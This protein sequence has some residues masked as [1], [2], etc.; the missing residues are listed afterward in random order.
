MNESFGK[1]KRGSLNVSATEM[2]PD[3]LGG[4]FDSAVEIFENGWKEMKGK[5]I[6]AEPPIGIGLIK[7]RSPWDHHVI[8]R[9]IYCQMMIIRF[10]LEQTVGIEFPHKIVECFPP[11]KSYV[12]Y[13]KS[14]DIKWM[15][16]PTHHYLVLN[17]AKS[18][19]K[20]KLKQQYQ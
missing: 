3:V 1:I 10:V 6:N 16:L 14:R 15:V 17:N 7:V 18:L 5:S 20:S 11:E 13:Y 4:S 8:E 19:P 9:W 12:K 2:F